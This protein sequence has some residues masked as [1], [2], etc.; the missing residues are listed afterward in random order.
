MRTRSVCTVVYRVP[1]SLV[2]QRVAT[3]ATKRALP[4]TWAGLPPAGSHQLAAGAPIRSPHRRGRA[5]GGL[6]MPIAV[7]I[8]RLMTSSN[9]RPE[10]PCLRSLDQAFK[11]MGTTADE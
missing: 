1:T 4:L 11:A 3:L 8:L 10:A 2:V 9:S 5:C 6:A 7:A